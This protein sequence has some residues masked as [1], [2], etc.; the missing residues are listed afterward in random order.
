[1][2]GNLKKINQWYINGGRLIIKYR[3]FFLIAILALDII[4]FFG[5]G[6]I[7]INASDQG[8]FLKDSELRSNTKLFEKYFGNNDFLALLVESDDIFNPDVLKMIREL[9]ET[10][11]E[12]IPLCDAV[13]SLANFEIPVPTPDGFKITQLIPDSIPKGRADLKKL[14]EGVFSNKILINKL[15]SDD[16]K[17]TWI[18][19]YL[20]PYPENWEKDYPDHPEQMIGAKVTEILKRKKFRNY[21][22]NAGGYPVTQYEAKIFFL[23]ETGRDILLSILVSILLLALFLRSVKGILFP[24]FTTASSL[25]IVYGAMGYIGTEVN[26]MVITIPVFLGMAIS[27]GYSVHIFNFFRYRFRSTGKRKE[28]IL[29]ALE[30]TGWPI[31]FTALTTFG[32]LLS[33]T[34]IPIAILRWMGLT[35]AL[36]VIVIY[37]IVIT[38]TPALLSFGRQEKEKERYLVPKKYSSQMLSFRLGKFIMKRSGLMAG[39][40]I[41]LILIFIFFSFGTRI[42]VDHK[43][44][45]GMKLNYIKKAHYIAGTKIGS[46]YCYNVTLEFQD[47]DRVKDPV[48]LK[49]LEKFISYA[50][51]LDLIKRVT[52]VNDIVKEL[53]MVMHGGKNKFFTVPDNRELVSQL[54]LLYEMSGGD[55]TKRWVDYNYKFLRILMEIKD[56]D[57]TLILDEQL[58]LNKIAKELFPNAK[59]R[60]SGVVYRVA[61]IQDY[62]VKGELISFGAAMLIVLI[63]M[64]LVFKSI[65]AGLIGV[66][67]ILFSSIAVLG[68][69]GIFNIPLNL[70]TMTIIPILLGIGV[71]DSIHFINHMKFE[72][73]RGQN[74]LESILRSFKAVGYALFITSFILVSIFFIYTTSIVKMF[75]HFGLVSS[76][77]VIA[78]LAGT[79]I[80]IPIL[81]RKIRPFED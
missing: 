46:L 42:N 11:Q 2:A 28:S 49:N 30:H 9:G 4:A 34:L 37:L 54:F 75:V 81:I 64:S 80:F 74:T 19:V 24:L 59:I 14:K 16:S 73:D 58:K 41:F 71:D 76:A 45:F 70:I 62:I 20:K 79:Y 17:Q 44:T 65:K 53:N 56:Y 51:S 57:T 66:T 61:H 48:I 6:K 67:P 38:I 8:L 60:F 7:K 78:A 50:K 43:N 21:K 40:L 23:K 10:L 22:I 27:I 77:G 5:L 12:E 63:L 26:N 35:T 18:I 25:L 39:I 31:F 29:Y 68:V 3:W 33:F 13:I 47:E 1:M 15:F 32:S 69:L 36:I 55:E 72:T 52:S